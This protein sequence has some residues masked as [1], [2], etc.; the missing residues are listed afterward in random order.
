MAKLATRSVDGSSVLYTSAPT[1]AAYFRRRAG[2]CGGGGPLSDEPY[3]TLL[4]SGSTAAGCDSADGGTAVLGGCDL[5]KVYDFAA[6]APDYEPRD[7][8]VI[9]CCPRHYQ[10]ALVDAQR[11][12]PSLESFRPGTE[13]PP[14]A[15]LGECCPLM[16]AQQRYGSATAAVLHLHD[17]RRLHFVHISLFISMCC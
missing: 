3:P 9:D 10:M 7:D 4:V 1:M 8:D 15:G 5:E 11:A 13:T 16:S 2:A 6:A 12:P 17:R 14:T